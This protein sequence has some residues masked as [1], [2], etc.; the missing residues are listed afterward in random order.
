MLADRFRIEASARGVVRL[1]PGRGVVAASPAARRH[2]ERA[3]A[4]LA[5]YFAGRRTAFTVPVDLA[6]VGEFQA[7]VLAVTSRLGY[8]A[9]TS[10]RALA[11]RVGAARAARAVGN[12]LATNPV[13]I[14]VPCHRV[15]RRDGTWGRYA[16]GGALK[17]ALLG[18]EATR[19]P[20]GRPRAGGGRNRSAA[21]SRPR[22]D[23]P[24]GPRRPRDR[25]RLP[26]RPG[27]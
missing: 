9:R 11:R 4:E 12:A 13:P 23:A 22:R 1:A 20:N 17:T 15:I 8:G 25:A 6:G 7:R 21:A 16:F 18:L 27:A 5:E 26:S 3:R 19:T 2:A 14:L 10:Y 24:S